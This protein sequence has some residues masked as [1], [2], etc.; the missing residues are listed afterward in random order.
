MDV[1]MSL[2]KKMLKIVATLTLCTIGMS[3]SHKLL[4]AAGSKKAKSD[5]F[6]TF[7]CESVT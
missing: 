7:P 5:T 4:A 2:H 6:I 3:C 1:S